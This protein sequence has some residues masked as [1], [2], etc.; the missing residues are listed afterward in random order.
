M[1]W[2]RPARGWMPAPMVNRRGGGGRFILRPLLWLMWGG[3]G[4]RPR[5]SWRGGRL[6]WRGRRIRRCGF[7]WM[8]GC[9]G[10]LGTAPLLERRLPALR[11]V[12]LPL[13]PRVLRRGPRGG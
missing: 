12:E 3:G 13:A 2:W 5:R 9:W 4:F 11:A 7:G 10:R 1:G 6:G 8:I